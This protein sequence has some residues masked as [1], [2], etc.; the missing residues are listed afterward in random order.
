VDEQEQLR[1]AYCAKL[2][3]HLRRAFEWRDKATDEEVATLRFT[4]LKSGECKNVRLE[5]SSASQGF[6][7]AAE[8]AV[9]VCSPMRPIPFP[10]KTTLSI[11][12]TF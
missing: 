1:Q 10:E 3:R 4:I 6:D 11:E 5:K 9:R 12:A 7:K 2:G 8:D